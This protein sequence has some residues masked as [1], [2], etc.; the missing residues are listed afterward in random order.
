VI[1]LG[2]M[3]V[4]VVRSIGHRHSSRTASGTTSKTSI[5]GSIHAGTQPYQPT[6]F[7]ALVNMGVQPGDLGTNWTDE[8]PQAFSADLASPPPDCARYSRVFDSRDADAVHQYSF[9][10]QNGNE[11]GG[12][13]STV[14]ENPSLAAV[15]AELPAVRTNGF[16]PCAEATAEEWLSR[17]KDHI[18][19]ID[20]HAAPI[21][22][23]TAANVVGWRATVDYTGVA[24]RA[25]FAMDIFYAAAR[26]Y[27]ANIRVSLCPCQ[28]QPGTSLGLVPDEAQAVLAVSQRITQASQT[29]SGNITPESN[30]SRPIALSDPCQL[31]TSAQVSAVIGD[32]KPPARITTGDEANECT[33]I[34]TNGEG[35]VI[36][37]G[38]SMTQFQTRLNDSPRPLAGLGDQAAVDP[39]FAGKVLVRKGNRWIWVFVEGT[40]SDR[41]NAI[42]LAK[43]VL[44]EL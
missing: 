22:L 27:V 6:S 21:G 34:G 25:T 2:A 32:A 33:W 26:N 42:N 15:A 8:G 41:D 14:I 31:L 17:R 23:V 28:A 12:L 24:G 1:A 43:A 36:Q 37:S 19:V 13:S 5:A 29:P 38:D 9:N 40:T 11:E 4:L 16:A 30:P 39:E 7:V 10:L 18:T 35:V 20:L 3:G 44:P